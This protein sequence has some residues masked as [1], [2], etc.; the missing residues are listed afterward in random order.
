MSE[1]TLRMSDM[2]VQIIICTVDC[3]HSEMRSLGA[4]LFFGISMTPRMSDMVLQIRSILRCDL[5]EAVI[6]IFQ[7]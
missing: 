6:V 2:T 1:M 7:E 5:L 3:N 4:I